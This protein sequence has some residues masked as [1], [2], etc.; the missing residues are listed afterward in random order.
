MHNTICYIN[1]IVFLDYW[2]SICTV[3]FIDT[4]S[5]ILAYVEMIYNILKP[6]G[7]W[8]NLGKTSHL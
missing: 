7:Y 6:G 1:S 2:D 8:I 4:A 3:Y 5:N